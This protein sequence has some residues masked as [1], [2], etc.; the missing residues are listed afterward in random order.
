MSKTNTLKAMININ[1]LI[2]HDKN[3]TAMWF[4]NHELFPNFKISN[5][6]IKAIT[7]INKLNHQIPMHKRETAMLISK[8]TLIRLLNKIRLFLFQKIELILFNFII[9]T[10]VIKP[11][12]SICFKKRIGFMFSFSFINSLNNHRNCQ[13]ISSFN[14]HVAKL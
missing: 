14:C 10:Y 9:R 3:R 4:L 8:I 6:N 12:C 13:G 11:S 5:L 1:R 2:N 7:T